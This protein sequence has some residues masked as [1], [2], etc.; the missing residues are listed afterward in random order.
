[1]QEPP[2]SRRGQALCRSAL[3]SPGVMVSA[4]FRV[5]FRDSQRPLEVA[6]PIVNPMRFERR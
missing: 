3:Q 2:G 6:D 1:M 4:A 5:P